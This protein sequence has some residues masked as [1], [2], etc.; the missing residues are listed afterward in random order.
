M[1]GLGGHLGHLACVGRGDGAALAMQS[2]HCLSQF[3]NDFPVNLAQN[4]TQSRKSP[5]DW[6]DMA[7]EGS[8]ASW[9]MWREVNGMS[10]PLCGA[11]RALVFGCLCR[12]CG[13][14]YNAEGVRKHLIDRWGQH[15]TSG[16]SKNEWLPPYG[17]EYDAAARLYE[18]A[19]APMTDEN[20]WNGA[21]KTR[22][23]RRNVEGLAECL[24]PEDVA[25]FECVGWEFCAMKPAIRRS[26]RLYSADVFD[27]NERLRHRDVS[28]RGDVRCLESWG[29]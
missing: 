8:A 27:A 28:F 3:L 19:C 2:H 5:G 7:L 1:R 4:F 14:R 16:W 13:E 10:V 25:Y 21:Q 26:A 29:G 22:K 20:G 15:M 23:R 24:A 9:K 12:C 17:E 18:G 11:C 6:G